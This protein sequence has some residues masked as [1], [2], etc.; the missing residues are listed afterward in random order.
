MSPVDHD[1]HVKPQVA[2][3]IKNLRKM[4]DE[5]CD[6]ILCWTSNGRAFEIRDMERMMEDVLPKYFKHCKYTSFQRQ[7]NYFNFKK[8][9]KS[10][11]VVCTF[12]NEYFVRDQPALALRILRKPST[13]SVRVKHSIQSSAG[14]NAAPTSPT[15]CDVRW[16]D[17]KHLAIVIPPHM[18]HETYPESFPSPTDMDMM[19][20]ENENDVHQYYNGQAMHDDDDGM[21]SLDWIDCFLPS[22]EVQPVRSEELMYMPSMMHSIRL[23]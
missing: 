10:K 20:L 21:N 17:K 1:R 5:E 22:L 15:S 9:T 7:L 11:A 16:Q 12:S 4:L 13:Q 6:E 19:L 8:W 14:V 3:F 2:P 18:N 23:Y